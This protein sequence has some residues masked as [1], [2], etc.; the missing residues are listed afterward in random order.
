MEKKR[1]RMQVT[2]SEKY[3]GEEQTFESIR[4]ASK[5]FGMSATRLSQIISGKTPNTTR[6]FI[7]T[8]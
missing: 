2:F 8:D 6:Y 4:K 3:T 7:T 5:H 1:R